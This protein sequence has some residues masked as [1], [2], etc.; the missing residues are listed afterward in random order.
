MNSMNWCRQLLA[1]AV[2]AGCLVGGLAVAQTTDEPQQPRRTIFDYRTELNLTEQQ[3]RDIRKLLADLNRDLRLARAKLTILQYDLEDM[4]D[5]EEDLKV[6]RKTLNEEA[7]LRARLRYDDLVATRKIN[8]V[9]SPAQ[10][11][12]W[13]GIQAAARTG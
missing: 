5:K 2:L 1:T 13:R 9:L 12:Q 6:I 10:L 7:G 4:I 3:E 11:Q 8:N